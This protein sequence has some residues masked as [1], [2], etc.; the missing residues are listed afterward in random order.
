ML[1]HRSS[2]A[3][4]ITYIVEGS[5]DLTDSGSWASLAISSGGNTT[6]GAGFVTETGSAPNFTVEVRDTIPYDGNPLTKRFLRLKV[7]SP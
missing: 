3:T 5:S 4:D 6:T 1:F 2:L 7:T